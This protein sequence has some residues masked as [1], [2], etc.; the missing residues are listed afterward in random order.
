[1]RNLNN[2]NFNKMLRQLIALRV[3][4]DKVLEDI[5]DII[6]SKV[7]MKIIDNCNCNLIFILYLS[8]LY[9]NTILPFY[10]LSC[11]HV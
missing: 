1:M 10:M 6:Y 3:E 8:R 4:T 11:V 7:G 9:K 5:A 2:I